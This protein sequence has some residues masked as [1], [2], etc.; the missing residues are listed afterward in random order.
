MD[1]SSSVLC[2]VTA[3]SISGVE[4]SG[5]ATT[6][7]YILPYQRFVSIGAFSMPV[8]VIWVVIVNACAQPFQ[9]M[10]RSVT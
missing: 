1:G 7:L 10:R 3:F 2:L 9:L 6:V 5:S 4:P 8:A